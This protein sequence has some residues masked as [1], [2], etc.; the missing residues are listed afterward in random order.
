MPIQSLAVFCG[1]KSGND[2][3]FC[4][5]AKQ[6]GFLLAQKKITLIYGGGNKGVMGAIANA[7]LKKNGKVIGIMPKL[8]TGVEHQHFGVTEMHEVTDM[9]TRKRMLYEKCDAALILPGGYG[10]MDEFFE[11]LTWNQLNIHE[12]KIFILN[13]SGFYDHLIAFI[14]KMEDEKFLYN[15]LVNRL[16]I[17]STPDELIFD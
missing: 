1:S 15:K 10:T 13:T 17:V 12:K 14:R 5:H 9:H 4:E 11:M 7:V 6:L 16:N 3:L 2:P 8:L